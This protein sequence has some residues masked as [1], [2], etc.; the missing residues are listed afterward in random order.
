MSTPILLLSALPL[1]CF[2]Y[3]SQRFDL[4]LQNAL[5]VGTIRSFVQL[6]ILGW[7]LH[8]IFVMGLDW[9]WL[10]GLC[11]ICLSIHTVDIL[12]C[13]FYFSLLIFIH[14]HNHICLN[15]TYEKLL[16]VLRCTLHDYHCNQRVHV[17][18]KIYIPASNTNDLPL[19]PDIHHSSGSVCLPI[20]NTSRSTLGS[21]ICHT[22]MWDV[23]GKLH[24]WR[25]V[26]GEQPHHTNYGGWEKRD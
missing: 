10:V 25:V 19:H 8:P 11:E 12:M 6:M 4:G 16:L 26:D 15:Y 2:A 24:Q 7:I 3:I 20:H 1:L 23:N 21:A 22:N 5:V 17:S 14:F 18:S 13:T 9:P